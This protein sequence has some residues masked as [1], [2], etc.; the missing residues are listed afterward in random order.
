MVLGELQAVLGRYNDGGKFV[1]LY[2]RG[3]YNRVGDSTS[4]F[5]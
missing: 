5:G 1:K 3:V 4:Q 2:R